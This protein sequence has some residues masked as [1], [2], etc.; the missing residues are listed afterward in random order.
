MDAKLLTTG[1]REML[2][3]VR[4]GDANRHVSAV[5]RSLCLKL[6]HFE[7]DVNA[8]DAEKTQR[9]TRWELGSSFEDALV[10]AMVERRLKDD[11]ARYARPGE[12]T[13]DGLIGTPDLLDLTDWAVIEIK[14][15]WLS[16]RHDLD[17]VKFWKYLVQIMAYC[18]MV[19][20]RLGHLH[21]CHINGDY[22]KDRGPTYNVW[23]CKF[24]PQEIDENFRMLK[25]Q[26]DVMVRDSGGDRQ[27]RRKS[28]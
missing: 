17:S 24:T 16:S 18:A 22:K 10:A 25:S 9:Q 1:I 5:I 8:T 20:T 26:S 21:V 27:N 28:K 2:P 12:L 6:G 13:K 11:P 3:M 4:T 7:D 23:E 19:G 15:T 14:L